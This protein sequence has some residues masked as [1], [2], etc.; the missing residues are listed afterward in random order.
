MPVASRNEDG[1][2]NSPRLKYGN[3]DCSHMGL[4]SVNDRT[5]LHD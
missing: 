2:K 4:I 5:L 3:M 1:W